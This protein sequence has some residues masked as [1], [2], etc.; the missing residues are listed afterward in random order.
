MNN[1]ELKEES[2]IILTFLQKIN[3]EKIKE[4]KKIINDDYFCEFNDEEFDKINSYSTNGVSEN[5]TSYGLLNEKVLYGSIN[6]DIQHYSKLE[7]NIDYINYTD[8]LNKSDELISFEFSI[9]K[10]EYL[11]KCYHNNGVYKYNIETGKLD[12]TIGKNLENIV[13]NITELT[14]EKIDLINI[15]YD[16]DIKKTIELLNTI[17]FVKEKIQNTKKNSNQIKI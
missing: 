13:E 6:I 8:E 16:I 17:E 12:I 11:L 4:L 14:E 7:I 2:K 5:A 15:Q 1:P 9:N 3:F 10:N